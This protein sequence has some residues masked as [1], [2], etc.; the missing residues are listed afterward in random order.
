MI[1]LARKHIPQH[2]G[3]KGD[4]GDAGVGSKEKHPV[5]SHKVVPVKV[6]QSRTGQ[7]GA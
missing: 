1:D 2:G 7:G 3:E 4:I 5:E 6:S